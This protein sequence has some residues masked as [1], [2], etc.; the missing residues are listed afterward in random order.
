MLSSNRRGTPSGNQERHVLGEVCRPSIIVT[1]ISP[2]SNSSWHILHLPAST[3]Y[4]A[5]LICSL[6]H[7][8]AYRDRGSGEPCLLRHSISLTSSCPDFSILL[9]KAEIY[10][11][12]KNSTELSAVRVMMISFIYRYDAISGAPG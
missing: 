6:G 12:S 1:I 10:S 7:M 5:H 3:Y 9:N 11:A 4:L 2:D 8:I